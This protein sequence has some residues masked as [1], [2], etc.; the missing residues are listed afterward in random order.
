MS[1]IWEDIDGYEGL[2]KVS[3][4]GKVYSFVSDKMLKPRTL[5]RYWGVCLYNG[6]AKKN[7]Y[8][9]KLVAV[10]FLGPCPV[11]YEID[12]KD[13]DKSNNTVENLQYLTHAENIAK[14]VRKTHCGVCGTK[15]TGA[16]NRCLP[17]KVQVQRRYMERKRN[18]GSTS[19]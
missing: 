17:C 6:K 18:A 19:H 12:H 2:Y 4:T 10:A 16:N 7:Y 11:G 14:D 15:K 13:N 3:S 1:E 8:L 9:H 5:G